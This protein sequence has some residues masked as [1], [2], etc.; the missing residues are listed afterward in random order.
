MIHIVRQ[1]YA[2]LNAF[3]SYEVTKLLETDADASDKEFAEEAP[4]H[5]DDSKDEN[6]NG[7]EIQEEYVI[8]DSEDEEDQP[9]D[10]DDEI[11]LEKIMNEH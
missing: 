1:K 5:P 11:L 4:T 10:V 7:D 3:K 8:Q 9:E 6:L 2:K